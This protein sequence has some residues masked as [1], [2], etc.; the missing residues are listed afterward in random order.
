MSRQRVLRGSRD[1]L[2]LT[3][4]QCYDLLE[5]DRD[6]SPSEADILKAY[7]RLA[8]KYHPDKY[9]PDKNP[10]IIEMF[11]RVCRAFEILCPERN[12]LLP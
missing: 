11:H 7:K 5:L 6:K 9:H 1:E 8:I 3:K 2:V 12:L 4:Q 10:E